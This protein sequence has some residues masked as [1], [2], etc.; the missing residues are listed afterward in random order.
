MPDSTGAERLTELAKDI[1]IAMFTTVDG[2][3][4]LASRPMAQQEVD[5]D[6]T[7]WFFGERDS[8]IVQQIEANPHVGVTLSSSDVWISI[9]GEAEVLVDAAKAEALWNPFVEAWLPQGP[10]DPSVALIRFSAVAAEYWDTPGGRVASVLSFAK[11]LGRSDDTVVR[12]RLAYLY[13]VDAAGTLLAQRIST[14]PGVAQVTVGRN[15]MP[16][17]RILILLPSAAVPSTWEKLLHSP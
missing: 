14:T 2:E 3:G 1:T 5:P 16:G 15:D 9:D 12:D 11:K 4:H 17:M 10:E 13:P 7:L 8:N 6:G